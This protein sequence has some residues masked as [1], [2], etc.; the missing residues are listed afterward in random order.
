[1]VEAIKITEY[2]EFSDEELI[3]KILGGEKDLYGRIM[4]KHNQRLYRIAL[5]IVKEDS[6]VEDIMQETY[7]KAYEQLP[8]FERRSAFSTW[9]IRILI[10]EALS[11]IKRKRRIKYIDP[12]PPEKEEHQS[13]YDLTTT[14][15]LNPEEKTLN[16][17]LKTILE[18]ALQ[19]LPDKYRSV[20]MMR[21]VEDMS[22][23]E[24]GACLQLSESN[25]KVRLNRAKEMLR[26]SLSSY[27]QEVE[28][29]PF[30]RTRCDRVT[31]HVL[32]RIKGY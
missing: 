3:E 8:R 25:V 17:E 7:V 24:T 14:D 32:N 18:Q 12:R 27:Y 19:K 15:I 11:H 6:E 31:T 2:E 28:I 13:V 23:A 5:S 29:Y 30:L 20:Y 26:E 21:E 16:N 4:R 1:M 10:S 9:L 22:I